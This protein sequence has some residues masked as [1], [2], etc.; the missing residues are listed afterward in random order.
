[1]RATSPPRVPNTLPLIPSSGPLWAT[2]RGRLPPKQSC[3]GKGSSHLLACVCHWW[4]LPQQ[5]KPTF[6]LIWPQAASRSNRQHLTYS[7]SSEEIHDHDRNPRCTPPT[8]T[9]KRHLSSCMS[10]N[11]RSHQNAALYPAPQSCQAARGVLCHLVGSVISLG[12]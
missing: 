3:S 2:C 4:A 6:K 7:F 5:N 9:A 1:M 11:T 10:G 8:E 12:T